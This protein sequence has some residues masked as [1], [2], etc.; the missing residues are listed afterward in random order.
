MMEIIREG[1]YE[2]QALCFRCDHCGTEFRTDE[3]LI[4]HAPRVVGEKPSKERYFHATCPICNHFITHM[5]KF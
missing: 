4:M 2:K 3:Y 1:H 5:V